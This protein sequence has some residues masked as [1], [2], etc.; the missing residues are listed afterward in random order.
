MPYDSGPRIGFVRIKGPAAPGQP[1]A[2]EGLDV[3][4]RGHLNAPV[5]RKVYI[6][7]RAPDWFK[8]FAREHADKLTQVRV[9]VSELFGPLVAYVKPVAASLEELNEVPDLHVHYRK[10]EPLAHLMLLR[11]HQLHHEIAGEHGLELVEHVT[12]GKASYSIAEDVRSHARFRIGGGYFALIA[13][14]QHAGYPDK[15]ASDRKF[16]V[17]VRPFP[18]DELV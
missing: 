8:V 16:L 7:P 3:L 4:G 14:D 11:V 13:I 12:A 15:I 9:K 6:D 18:A 2:V 5:K 1:H 17:H 10:E